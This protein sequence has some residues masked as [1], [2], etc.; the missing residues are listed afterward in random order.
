LSKFTQSETQ[1][2]L[3]HILQIVSFICLHKKQ[4][5]YKLFHQEQG[6]GRGYIK[7]IMATIKWLV[8]NNGIHKVIQT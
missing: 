3:D 4:T 5:T 6:I 8:N 2:E 7:K 1:N